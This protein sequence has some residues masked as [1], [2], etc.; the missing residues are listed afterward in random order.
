MPRSKPPP[1]PGARVHAPPFPGRRRDTIEVDLAW[2]EEVTDRISTLPADD[3]AAALR[4]VRRSTSSLPP[5]NLHRRVQRLRESVADMPAAS[6]PTMEVLLDWLE[7]EDGA[8]ARP[9]KTTLPPLPK[10][11]KLA[12]TPKKG[13]PIPRGED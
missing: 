1:L 7:P 3:Q 13:P 2:L 12:R 9:R 6:R 5:A 4:E 11:T 8:S 10:A